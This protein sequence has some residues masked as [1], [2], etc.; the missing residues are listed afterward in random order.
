MI[1]VVVVLVL[2]SSLVLAHDHN[3][4]VMHNNGTSPIDNLVILV[5]LPKSG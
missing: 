2:L 3:T 5:G 1:L 4:M